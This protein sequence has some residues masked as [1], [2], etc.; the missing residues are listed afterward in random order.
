MKTPIV[1]LE[2]R[3]ILLKKEKTDNTIINLLPDFNDMVPNTLPVVSILAIG[4]IYEGNYF[5]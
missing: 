2:K 3:K 4:N 1:A 5:K